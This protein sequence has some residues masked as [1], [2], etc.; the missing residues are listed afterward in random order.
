MCLH[1][2]RD[3]VAG[4][5]VERDRV[6]RLFNFNYRIDSIGINFVGTGNVDGTIV[7]PEDPTLTTP[8][9]NRDERSTELYL[10]DAIS[11]DDA[12]GLGRSFRRHCFDEDAECVTPGS[13]G[14]ELQAELSARL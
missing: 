13:G 6:E 3:P 1:G 12:R 11:F 8:S 2:R 14:A 9:T 5:R 10:R 4:Q 7:T